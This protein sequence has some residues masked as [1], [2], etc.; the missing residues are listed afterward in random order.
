MLG[1]PRRSALF[2][3][4]IHAAAVI[5]IV[6]ATRFTPTA[7]PTQAAPQNYVPIYL[8]PYIP[9]V[10]RS[11]GGG[12]GGDRDPRPAT[13]GHLPRISVHQFTPP[14]AVYRNERPLLAMEPTII[15]D[16]SIVPPP[17]PFLNIGDPNGVAGPPSNGPGKNGGIGNG[18]QG[19]VGDRKGPGGGNADDGGGVSG[20]IRPGA[21]V[22]QPYI[23]VKIEPEYSDE[24]R[25]A[26]IQG[27]VLLTIQVDERGGVRNIV[28]KQGLGLGLDD[29]AIEAVSRWK[30]RPG[31]VDGK[32]VPMAALVEVSFRLM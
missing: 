5:L 27:V 20:F 1:S 17:S 8:Q 9:H 12:G 22:I 30:F 23:L 15:G 11:T 32:P 3:I 18:D 28:V 21:K 25:R 4:L 19:G 10:A 7:L 26:R 16:P 24:A 31:T 29:K 14:T 6:V 2:S 13:Q